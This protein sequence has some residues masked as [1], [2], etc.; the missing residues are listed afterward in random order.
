MVQYILAEGAEQKEIGLHSNPF[1]ELKMPFNDLP[2]LDLIKACPKPQLLKTHLQHH[3]LAHALKMGQGKFIVVMRNPKDALASFY[4]FYKNSLLKFGGTFDD[5]MELVKT[6]QIQRGDLFEWYEDWWPSRNDQN[7]M[8]IMYEDI[9]NDTCNTIRKVAK[10]LGKSLSSDIVKKIASA[11]AFSNMSK[12][13]SFNSGGEDAEMLRKC[14]FRKGKV[15]DWQN[16]FNKDQNQWVEEKCIKLYD[17][18]LK[19]KYV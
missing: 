10:F 5:F 14:F 7:V 12:K 4:N 1:L 2:N 17:L 16:W 19:F 8:H 3:Y 6:K 18:G 13:A 15:G 9:I 11:I